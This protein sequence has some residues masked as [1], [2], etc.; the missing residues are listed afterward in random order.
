[1]EKSDF[2]IKTCGGNYEFYS[3]GLRFSST[4]EFS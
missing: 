3:D 2:R 1:M 4:N